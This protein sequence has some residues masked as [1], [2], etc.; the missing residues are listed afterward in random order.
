MAR[1]YIIPSKMGLKKFIGK[2]RLKLGGWKM[3]NAYPDLGNAV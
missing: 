1:L 2:T 3:V